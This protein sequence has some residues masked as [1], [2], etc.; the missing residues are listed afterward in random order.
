MTCLTP[1][2]SKNFFVNHRLSKK[3]KKKKK[4]TFKEKELFTEKCIEQKK[5]NEKKKNVTAF[6]TAIKQDPTTTL[7]YDTNELKVHEQTDE[8][9]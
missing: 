8:I 4:K 2:P 1:E 9:N 7:S 6:G 5:W 3:K